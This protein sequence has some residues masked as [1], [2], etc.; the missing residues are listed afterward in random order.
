MVRVRAVSDQ[1]DGVVQG[2]VVLVLAATEHSA[3]VELPPA[4]IRRDGQRSHRGQVGHGSLGTDSLLS[5]GE[6]GVSHYLHVIG[7][8]G[9]VAGD[10]DHRSSPLYIVLT[11]PSQPS[12]PG[13]VGV[14]SVGGQAE[15]LDVVVAQLGDGAAATSCASAVERVGG[16]GRHLGVTMS[17]Q[18]G[19]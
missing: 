1:L 4:G 7:W 10:G 3:A 15:Q 5:Q 6:G 16:A 18:G 8:K 17:H 13:E 19:G 14:V 11:P 9:V 2:D 12:H